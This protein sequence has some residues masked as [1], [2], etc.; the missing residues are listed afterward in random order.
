MRILRNMVGA[1]TRLWD[2]WSRNHGLIPGRSRISVRCQA[3]K[4]TLWPTQPYIH[5]VQEVPYPVV[6]HIQ[7]ESDYSPLSSAKVKNAQRVPQLLC[8]AS[9]NGV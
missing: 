8:V 6:K 3:S 2:G 4:R 1:S 5:S 7:C 9:R